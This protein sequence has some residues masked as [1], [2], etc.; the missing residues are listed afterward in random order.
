[1]KGRVQAGST[2][3]AVYAYSN[4]CDVNPDGLARNAL[5]RL[6]KKL[7]E[8]VGDV[9]GAEWELSRAKTEFDYW[10]HP[11]RWSDPEAQLPRARDY[12]ENLPGV[13]QLHALEHV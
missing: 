12:A 2:T 5:R 4:T 6:H 3:V 7:R 1:M 13:V 8:H 10:V 11:A 9:A